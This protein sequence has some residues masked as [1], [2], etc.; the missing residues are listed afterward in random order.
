[1]SRDTGS[2]TAG[3]RRGSCFSPVLYLELSYGLDRGAALPGVNRV[4]EG[5]IMESQVCIGKEAWLQ[6]DR[7]IQIAH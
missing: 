4:D 5:V 2:N 7:R 1:M 3:E 6:R